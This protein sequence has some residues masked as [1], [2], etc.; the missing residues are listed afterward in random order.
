MKVID[1]GGGKKKPTMTQ[2]A[3]S[4]TREEETG[5]GK[6]G[7][8]AK[9]PSGGDRK[10]LGIVPPNPNDKAVTKELQKLRVLTPYTV[11]SRFNLRVGVAK[12]FLEELCRQ[13]V[14]TEVSRG[15][16]LRIYRPSD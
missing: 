7:G 12:D 5:E 13:G 2:M 16:N 6:G 4:Q 3:K 10:T 1:M 11:A 8:R 15:R 14:I 9:T